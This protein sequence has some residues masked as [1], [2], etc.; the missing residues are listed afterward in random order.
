MGELELISSYPGEGILL[1][2]PKSKVK[3]EDLGKL[4]YLFKIPKSMEIHAPEVYEQVY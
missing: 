2:N 3:E 1:S 4:R